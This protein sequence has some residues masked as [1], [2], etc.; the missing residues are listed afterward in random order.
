MLLLIAGHETTRSLI[1]AAVLALLR[2]PAEL[3]ALAADPSLVGQAV[4]EAL[5]YDPP[6]QLVSRFA[7]RC[8]R[9][10]RDDGRGR[11]VRRCCCSGRPTATRRCARTRT[12]S[13]CG[14]SRRRHL[15]FGHGIHFCLGAPLARLEAAIAL[16][17][18]LPLLPRLRVA[19]EPRVEAEHGAARA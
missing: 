3:A 9:N 2:H 10:S 19:G 16:R 17:Q 7:L 13:P 11:L 18:L 14:A 12:G 15:A 8:T 5:R 4:E 1:G 6:V